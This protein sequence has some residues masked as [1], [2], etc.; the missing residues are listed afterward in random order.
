VTVQ[1]KTADAR[2]PKASVNPKFETASPQRRA[3]LPGER[4]AL[5]WRRMREG[6]MLPLAGL[7]LLVGVVA[8]AWVISEDQRSSAGIRKEL[9][10]DEAARLREE[11]DER[12]RNFTTLVQRK[13][14]VSA[15]DLAELE[16]AVAAQERFIQAAGAIPA[17]TN[18][19]EGLRTKLHLF[20]AEA[21]R[22]SSIAAEKAAEEAQASGKP[23]EAIRRLREALALE[24][25]I[26]AKWMLSNLE[27]K[28]RVTRLDFRLRRL[29]A[30]PLWKE[31]R[32]L[33]AEARA[34]AKAGD[35]DG[36]ENLLR[37]AIDLERTFA[38]RYR[39]VRAT[40]FDRA[41]QLARLAEDFRSQ[42]AKAAL[43]LRVREA[44]Q[45]EQA[46]E[47]TRAAGMWAEAARMSADIVRL[48]PTSANADDKLAITYAR[49]EA[50]ARAMPDVERF[51][52]SMEEVRERLRTGEIAQA[53]AVAAAAAAR[54]DVLLRQFPEALSADD[55]DRR[56]LAVVQ[57]RLSSLAVVREIFVGQLVP[58]PAHPGRRILRTEVNQALYQAVMGNNPSA[59]RDPALPAESMDHAQAS[60]F[61][62]RL[63]W[64]T[65]LNV[66]LPSPEELMAGHQADGRSIPAEEAWTL[67]TSDGRVRPVGTSQ[68][69]PAGIH[70]LM[71]NVAEWAQPTAAGPKAPVVGGDAQSVPEGTGLPVLMIG[72]GETS[73]LRGFRV[74]VT[75]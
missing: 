45:A 40:E 16:A 53:G 68:S 17:E 46:S 5:A 11:V 8:A 30:D 23:D 74:I 52:G 2:F 57:E 20:R 21:L 50:L 4:K 60:E 58:L 43:D 66:R 12:E 61:A 14:R 7:L 13:A 64:L 6:L 34:A 37:S 69:N 75:P 35:F 39:D 27:D 59:K 1:R 36:A 70:D 24:E 32:R 9:S 56:Q 55:L 47:W 72:R 26:A 29:E 10:E 71:G 49:R 41:D 22:E 73:R 28:G 62:R 25:E 3:D 48:H 44:E 67:D 19:L 42:A 15:E 51:R 65:G 63:G 38:L 54:L 31:G 18:R 33:E